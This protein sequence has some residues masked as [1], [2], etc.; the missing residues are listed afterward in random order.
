MRVHMYVSAKGETEARNESIYESVA[1]SGIP[2]T[3]LLLLQVPQGELQEVLLAK[4]HCVSFP[5]IW[6]RAHSRMRA[7]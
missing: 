7:G 2:P 6:D 5:T 1:L 4:S 3:Q